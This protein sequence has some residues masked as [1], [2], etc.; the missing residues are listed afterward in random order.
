M[1]ESILATDMTNHAKN[2]TSLKN[3]CLAS[4]ITNGENVSE[5]IEN[6]DP[7]IKFDN[8]QL[9]LSNL[10][11][12][13]DISNPAKISKVYKKWVDLV[14]VEF[15]YQGDCEKKESLPISLL[16][17]RQTTH[18]GKSQIGFIKFVVRPMFEC[19]KLLAPEINT[20]LDYINK[21][22]K[23]FE[24]DIKKEEEK[25]KQGEMRV[26]NSNNPMNTTGKSLFSINKANKANN[27]S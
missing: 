3:K 14:F 1:I 25:K 19:V 4:D 7:S 18:V 27:N 12:T 13:A 26:S 10:I 6:K 24:D 20:Y 11:H 5:I 17:D 23:M 22:L 8:Q 15:F 9:V 21:N 2:L 16:C